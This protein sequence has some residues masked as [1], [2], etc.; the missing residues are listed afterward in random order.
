[1]KIFALALV[2][3]AAGCAPIGFD[4]QQEGTGQIVH[5]ADKSE[6]RFVAEP[7]QYRL[8]ADQGHLVLFIG[9]PTDDPIELMDKSTVEDPTGTMHRLRGRV[10]DPHSAIKEVFPPL[11][12]DQP[13]EAQAPRRCRSLTIHTISR[14]LS[15]FPAWATGRKVRAGSG[16]RVWKSGS[17][18]FFNAGSSRSSSNS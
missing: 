16:M 8:I 5:V 4:F 9:N 2:W 3:L 17:I 10:I 6:A 1:M 14:A 18:C 15:R 11:E 13:E 12:E 7:L